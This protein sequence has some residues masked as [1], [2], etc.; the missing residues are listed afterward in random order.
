MTDEERNRLLDEMTDAVAE[1]VLYDSYTQTQAMSIALAQAVS[2]LDVHAR[3]I[4]R[5]EQVAGLNRELEFLPSEETI[6]A[7]RSARRGLVAPELATLMAYTKINLYV[8]LMDSDLPEDPY[9]AHDLERY[10]PEPLGPGSAGSGASPDE[11]SSQSSG[12]ERYREQMHRHRLRRE[13]IA[14]VVANQLVDRAGTTFAFR[15][16]EET[17]ACASQLARAYA[18]AREVF[19]MREFWGEVEAL[20]NRIEAGTQL[21]MLIEGRRLVERATRWLVRAHHRALDIEA[22]TRGFLPG[23]RLL[24]QAL[25]NVLG[26]LDRE[27]YAARHEE[28]VQAGVPDELARRVAS[29]QALLSVFDIV[30]DAARSGRPQSMVMAAYFALGSQLGL[31]WLRDRILELPR[32][33]R[34]QALARAALRDDLYRLHRALTRDAL[35]SAD[36]RRGSEG[37]LAA[38]RERNEAAVERALSVLADVKASGIYDTTT[39]PVALRELGDL[40]RD[41]PSLLEETR[42]AGER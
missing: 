30:Q 26:E 14:T 32:A 23:A 29:M 12:S 33:D 15:L 21:A 27:A 2:M 19:E 40:V 16:A 11:I 3:L 17:G 22:T 1:R 42:A 18:V 8:A 13:I 38:W 4:R 25:P 37:A 31:D 24:A 39:L 35:L 20:D 9:L 41:E 5:L 7:R 6:A 36:G 34:W 28:L 10:F